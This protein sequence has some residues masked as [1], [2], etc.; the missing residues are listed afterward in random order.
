MGHCGRN[1]TVCALAWGGEKLMADKWSNTY[2]NTQF[3]DGQLHYKKIDQQTYETHF[4][5]LSVGCQVGEETER[6][7]LY[8]ELYENL[9]MNRQQEDQNFCLFGQVESDDEV[10]N[11]EFENVQGNIRATD[12]DRKDLWQ[13]RTEDGD[14]DDG[15]GIVT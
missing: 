5:M 2:E 12:V 13:T 7:M 8:F 4:E 10:K 15:C 9:V 6:L 14:G 1:H 11:G 3:I